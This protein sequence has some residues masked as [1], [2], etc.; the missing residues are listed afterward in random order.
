MVRLLEKRFVTLMQLNSH[1]DLNSFNTIV[2]VVKKLLFSLQSRWLRKASDAEKQGKNPNFII[3]LISSKLNL[4][5][6]V[7]H[8]QLS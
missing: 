2:S 6:L 1:A 5:L 4:K 7:R 3:L 8:T